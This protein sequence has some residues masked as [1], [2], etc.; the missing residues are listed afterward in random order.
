MNLWFNNSLSLVAQ[1]NVY[2]VYYWQVPEE[3]SMILCFKL[4][5]TQEKDS[6]C[7]LDEGCMLKRYILVQGKEKIKNT[8]EG[9][10]YYRIKPHTLGCRIDIGR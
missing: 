8:A 3:K 5:S 10:K 4:L 1:L 6:I 9:S 2:F 7:T